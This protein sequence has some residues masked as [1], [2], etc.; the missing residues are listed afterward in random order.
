MKPSS[1]LLSSIL[2]D[3][4]ALTVVF[5]VLPFKAVAK[6]KCD[7]SNLKTLQA[8]LRNAIKLQEAFRNKA[9]ELRAL[10]KGASTIAL[11][12]FAEGD[13]RRGLE[14]IPGNKGPSEVDYIPWGREL[15]DASG[16]KYSAEQ[17]CNMSVSSTAVLELAIASAECSGIGEALR[18]HENVHINFCKK[19]GFLPYEDMHGADRAQEEAEAYGAQ[20]KVLRD[21]IASLRCGYRAT[22]QSFGMSYSGLICNLEQPFT[23]K[24][25]TMLDFT[26]HFTPSSTNAGSVA[27][28]MVGYGGTGEGGGTYTIQGLGTEKPRIEINGSYTG[29]FPQGS[30]VGSGPRL[31]DLVPLEANECDQK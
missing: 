23:I 13:A 11:K 26:F 30:A 29:R 28:E 12:Q 16:S 5:V 1:N 10:G 17:L 31:I 20:I 15:Y 2:R 14:P 19:I 21:V 22:G 3:F 27:I 7:C 18:A 9:N 6:D 24:G 8:E 4:L 25:K